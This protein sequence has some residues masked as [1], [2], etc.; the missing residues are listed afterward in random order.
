MHHLRVQRELDEPPDGLLGP[1]ARRLE[2]LILGTENGV[3]H[4]VLL[5]VE[6]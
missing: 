2:A 5:S 6:T 1:P 3:A 4:G